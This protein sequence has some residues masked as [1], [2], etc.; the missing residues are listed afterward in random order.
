[1][2][3]GMSPR[4]SKISQAHVASLALAMLHFGGNAPARK[5]RS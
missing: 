5:E 3:Q 4:R 1:M 2:A